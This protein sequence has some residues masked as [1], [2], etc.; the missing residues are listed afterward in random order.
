MI[1]F[2]ISPQFFGN[3][4]LKSMLQNDVKNSLTKP[5]CNIP[6]FWSDSHK[7]NK[8]KCLGKNWP[9]W[10]PLL[11][12]KSDVTKK[13]NLEIFKQSFYKYCVLQ[14]FTKIKERSIKVA[15]LLSF[16]RWE[17]ERVQEIG[18]G[19]SEKSVSTNLVGAGS[20]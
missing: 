15:F 14:Y 5:Y 6:N 11:F 20:R 4:H 19:K 13:N 12:S 7:R 18:T 17:Q 9:C 1:F 10:I 2:F 16:S 3:Y 8:Y